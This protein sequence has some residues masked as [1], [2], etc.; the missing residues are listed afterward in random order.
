MI[1]NLVVGS[2]FSAA[3]TKIFLGKDS[4]IIGFKKKNL[5]K[6]KNFFRRKTLDINKFF[7]KKTVSY[8]SLIFKLNKGKLHD[9]LISGG[10]ST[11]WGGH[12]N[13]RKLTKQITS[14]FEKKA[15][16][17]KLNYDKTGTTTNDKNIH[18]LQ[19]YSGNILNSNNILKKIENGYILSFF[20]K[21]KKIYIKLINQKNNKINQIQVN[22]LFLC[23]GTIQFL[24]LLY[25]SQFLKN[26]DLIEHSE[27]H[28]KYKISNIYSK[29]PR[30]NV[31]VIRYK[32]SRAIGHFLGV[33]Y[34]SKFLRLL[35]FI[36][37][38]IDQCFYKK[39]INYKL[40]LK[41]GEFIEKNNSKL[42]DNFGQSIHYCNL[43]INKIPINQIMKK[44]HPNIYGIGMSFIDQDVPGPIS[45]DIILDS[46][47]KTINI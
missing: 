20:I 30:G 22:K 39:K 27:Y 43:R 18:Q 15:K 38:S 45:N 16:F 21:K 8:G 47:K 7:S 40:L 41:N 35:D 19:T 4:K 26:G 14:F 44:I 46:Y 13:L 28:H 31:T 33:Q 2:G 23:I 1:K 36:P 11:I 5:F 24:D 29:L 42:C 34:Y 32:L 9:R 12:I 3:I 10:N 37:L 17:I 25:R 6:Y